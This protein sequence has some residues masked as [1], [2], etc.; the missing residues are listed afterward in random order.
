[1]LQMEFLP[2]QSL[3][4]YWDELAVHPDETQL[5][6]LFKVNILNISMLHM[7]GLADLLSFSDPAQDLMTP[8]FD[9]VSP[10][11]ICWNLKNGIY[12]LKR[13]FEMLT[14]CMVTL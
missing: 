10:K 3:K 9:E 4:N 1:M 13:H 2:I 14:F 12:I 6:W 7:H 5:N 11:V 8:N